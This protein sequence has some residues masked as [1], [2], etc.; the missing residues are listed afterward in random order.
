VTYSAAANSGAT[1]TGTI[2]IAGKTLTVTQP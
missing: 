2:S 1:R